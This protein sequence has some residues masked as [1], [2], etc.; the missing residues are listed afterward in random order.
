MKSLAAVLL[1]VATLCLG[2][3]SPVNAQDAAE[4]AKEKSKHKV[5]HFAPLKD[6]EAQLK[7]FIQKIARDLS[8]KAEYGEA[9]IKRVG[10]DASTVSVLA[11]TLAIHD[12]ESKFKPAASKLMALATEVADNADEFDDAKKAHEALAAVFAKPEKGDDV[13][14]DEPVA[15]LAM[16][17]QQVPIVNAGLR[18]GVDDKRRFSRNAKRTAPKA[19]TLAAIAN[20]SMLDTNYCS[21]EDDEK[22]W[23]AICA[24]M[25]D[26]C[27]DV[28]MA[29]MKKDQ[30]AAKEANQRV[31]E[32]CDACHDKFR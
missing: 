1:W 30:A 31:V 8:D 12:K 3:L 28:Y 13:V 25:R 17:M 14:L 22:A 20:A 26:A 27:A 18:K 7:Y 2:L 5:S 10:L 19:V 24:D 6:T 16:L 32:T 23:K 9:Q 21:D 11:F 29:L 4:G 15:D